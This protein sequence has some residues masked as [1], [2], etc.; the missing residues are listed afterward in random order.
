MVTFTLPFQ[1]RSLVFQHQKVL[2]AL[3]FDCAVT[4]L[5]DFAKNSKALG[6]DMGM[7]EVVK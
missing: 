5:K 3:L 4:T 7:T 6:G 2:Y 1:L